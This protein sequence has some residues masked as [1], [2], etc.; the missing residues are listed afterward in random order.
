MSMLYAF[1]PQKDRLLRPVCAAL[2]AAGVTPNVVTAAGVLLSA[3]AGLLALS[4]HLYAGILV[5]LA[6]AGLDALDGSLARTC[7]LGSEFGRYFDSVADRAS[8][9]LFIGGAIAGGAPLTAF[10]VVAGSLILL[11]SRI[12]NHRKGVTSDAAMFGRPERLAFLILGLLS[13]RPYST[14]LFIVAG[15]MCLISSV[16]ALASGAAARK[17]NSKEAR[18]T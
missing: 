2:R 5:F 15:L 7:G 16:Q 4:G 17:R 13:P 8:E 11:A 1:K 14:A 3:A 6:G 18:E 9:L 12:Y 10:A